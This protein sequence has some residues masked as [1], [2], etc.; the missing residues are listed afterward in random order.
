M[1]CGSKEVWGYQRMARNE[2]MQ[3]SSVTYSG[4]MSV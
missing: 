1:K 3:R 4:N 2:I